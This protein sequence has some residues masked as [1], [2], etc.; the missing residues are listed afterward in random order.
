M[1]FAEITY[2]CARDAKEYGSLRD[3]PVDVEGIAAL[4]KYTTEDSVP[5]L[6]KV[7][8][9]KCY[10]KDRT[11]IDPFAKFLWMLLQAMRKME[12]GP[13]MKWKS[14]KHGSPCFKP[15]EFKKVLPC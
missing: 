14:S 10:E 4:M 15:F 6:Y 1:E 5:S 7:L 2:D 9:E 3:D 11:R 12:P 8:N 13:C